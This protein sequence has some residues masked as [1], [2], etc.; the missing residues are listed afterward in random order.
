MD[1]PAW[2]KAARTMRDTALAD[3]QW[4]MALHLIN[5]GQLGATISNSESD[6]SMGMAKTAT[7]FRDTAE[8][9][10]VL[11][12]ELQ[13][14]EDIEFLANLPPPPPPSYPPPPSPV[15]L[16]LERSHKPATTEKAMSPTAEAG[17]VRRAPSSGKPIPL[18][19][20]PAASPDGRQTPPQKKLPAEPAKAT[21]TMN[22]PVEDKVAGDSNSKFQGQSSVEW[23]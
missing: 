5:S 13:E 10:A 12:R 6:G 11:D 22:L 20:F 9:A 18:S 8:I 7:G 3:S 19:G 23:R 21:E 15:P 4:V 1:P 2:T 16:A 17:T 14:E